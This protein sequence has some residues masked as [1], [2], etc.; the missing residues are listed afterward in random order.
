LFVLQTTAKALPEFEIAIKSKLQ[1]EQNE[2]IKLHFK[3]KG[4]YFVLDDF[5]SLQ[6][7]MRIKVSMIS[8]HQPNPGFLFFFF[9]SFSFLCIN[10]NE[11][12][13]TQTKQ[14]VIK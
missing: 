1:L 2:K 3:R 12:N 5:E 9:F 7:G 14:K 13:N 10:S 11:I 6:Y 4:F 8:K